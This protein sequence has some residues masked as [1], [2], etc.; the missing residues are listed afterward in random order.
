[1]T[2]KTGML[3][4]LD[5]V[6]VDSEGE[7]SVFWGSMG[8]KYG[9][10]ADFK[11][12]IKGETLTEILKQFPEGDREAIQNA[13]YD[14]EANMD[15]IIY[16]GVTEFFD[17]LREAGIPSAIVTSSD[18]AKMEKLFKR[19]PELRNAA[20]KVVTA[21]MV[22]KSKP[23]PQPYLIGAEAIGVPIEDC[24]VFEDSVNGLKSAKASGGT[25]VG[26][27]STNPEEVVASYADIL[28]TGLSEIDLQTL[29]EKN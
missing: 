1:M 5:G 11:D 24:F 14:F 3:F 15:Y 18:N 27:V 23:D 28:A 12:R 20:T 25:V 13:L 10:G 2:R 7:Y 16:P 22:T 29:L 17:R 4:D 9:L 6:L 26:I 19:R 21:D 8:D